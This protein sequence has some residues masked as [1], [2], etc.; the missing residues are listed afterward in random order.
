MGDPRAP[1]WRRRD[2]L[3][4]GVA[5]LAAPLSLGLS[6][7]GAS[8]RSIG[9]GLMRVLVER[10]AASIG[11]WSA[12]EFLPELHEVPFA[13]DQMLATEAGTLPDGRIVPAKR[14]A[15]AGIGSEAR[16]RI[17]GCALPHLRG[18]DVPAISIDILFE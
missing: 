18:A 1:S 13:S 6:A 2:F 12:S 7:Q 9:A 11:Y 10:D 5:G 15:P 16:I 3:A 14:I 8:G 4:V 17:A